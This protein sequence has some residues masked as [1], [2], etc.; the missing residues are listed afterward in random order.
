MPPHPLESAV[1]GLPGAWSSGLTI[2]SQSSIE[3]VRHHNMSFLLL[4]LCEKK[5]TCIHADDDEVSSPYSF[6]ICCIQKVENQRS[7]STLKSVFEW[8]SRGFIEFFT[9]IRLNPDCFSILSLLTS[10]PTKHTAKA[11]EFCSRTFITSYP[12]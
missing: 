9:L 6:F 7:I 2:G 4:S 5:L 1:R 10:F 3:G 11:R 12:L 8:T